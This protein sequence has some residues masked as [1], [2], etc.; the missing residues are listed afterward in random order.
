LLTE[1]AEGAAGLVENGVFTHPVEGARDLAENAG[2][3]RV[4][5][6]LAAGT[7]LGQAVAR[8]DREPQAALRAED[9]A[10]LTGPW[11]ELVREVST[12]LVFRD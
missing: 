4:E 5:E 3:P 10:A 8:S 2:L 1:V 12:A 11:D 9:A 7:P 6:L